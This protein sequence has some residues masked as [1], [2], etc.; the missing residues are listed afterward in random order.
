[1]KRGFIL[2]NSDLATILPYS[3]ET[4]LTKVAQKL[5]PK[6]FEHVKRVADTAE[7][8]AKKYDSDPVKARIAGIVHDYA[9]QF[10]D[11][12]FKKAIVTQK[13]DP[14]LLAYSNGIWH[15][16]VGTYFI[17]RDLQI[18]DEA[19]LS[20]VAKHTI[21]A[22]RAEMSKLDQIIF[23]ADFIEP[24]RDFPGIADARKAAAISLEAGVLYEL[25]ATL[26][27]LITN[28]KKVYPKTLENYNGWVD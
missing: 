9:K 18:Y 22:P 16:V 23:I 10:P 26:S 2:T 6:R 1:M 24:G 17:Q 13:F 27:F 15:G 4:L 28:N 20:A 12:A 21:A 25:K 7:A 5:K 11:E 8:L 14:T 3:Y 19:I